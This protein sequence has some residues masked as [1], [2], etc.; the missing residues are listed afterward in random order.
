MTEHQIYSFIYIFSTWLLSLAEGARIKRLP[1]QYLLER[2]NFS[3]AVIFLMVFL[4]FL[5]GVRPGTVGGDTGHYMSEYKEMTYG[6][7]ILDDDLSDWLFYNFQF[8]CAKIMPVSMFFLLVDFLYVFLAYL[9][10]RRFLWNNATWLFLFAMGAFSFFSY[11]VNGIRNGLASTLVL[12]ALSYLDGN[13]KDKIVCGVLCF[14]AFNCHKSSA[15]PIAAML[16][17]YFLK[18]PKFMFYAW[19]AALIG[20]LLIGESLSN[21]FALIGFDD[22]LSD[23]LALE[24]SEETEDA[25]AAAGFRWDFLIYSFMPILM[26]WYC[27][28]KKKI[29]DLKYHLILGTYVYANAVWVILIRIPFTNRFAYLSWFLYAIV[30]AYP[31]LKFPLWENQGRKV[32]MILMAHVSFTFLMHFY[33]GI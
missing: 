32:M 30:L 17:A 26:G 33:A 22:R 16:F 14:L 6:F 1:D 21:L 2:E 19:G 23:Y 24:E 12:L 5:M 29:C 3:K 27:I 13:L 25:I 18:K 20:S 28:Y 4:I 10:C 15:L 31:L 8:V 7:Y 9:A 11:G